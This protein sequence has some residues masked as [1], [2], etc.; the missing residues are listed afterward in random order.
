[1]AVI[2]IDKDSDSII[3]IDADG[4]R[5]IRSVRREDTVISVPVPGLSSKKIDLVYVNSSDQLVLVVD[6]GSEIT[7]GD[8]SDEQALA[9]ALSS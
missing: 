4:T 1:M 9:Y 8:V 3:F 5:T 2:T 6:S 7:V